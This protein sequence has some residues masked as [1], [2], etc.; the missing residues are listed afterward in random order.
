MKFSAVGMEV[1]G[2]PPRVSTS[3]LPLPGMSCRWHP[4]LPGCH[5][6]SRGA[7]N[8]R[9]PAL[10][11]QPHSPKPGHQQSTEPRPPTRRPHVSPG[12]EEAEVLGSSLAPPLEEQTRGSQNTDGAAAWPGGQRACILTDQPN[13]EH[14][15]GVHCHNCSHL[16]PLSR[17][18]TAGPTPSLGPAHTQVPSLPA[19]CSRHYRCRPRLPSPGQTSF[20]QPFYP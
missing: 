17:L 11:L 9:S 16:P 14:Q 19:G 7:A 2:H 4:G 10:A 12:A 6:Y 13:S 8:K 5:P 15:L 18:R 20:L 1:L 3:V